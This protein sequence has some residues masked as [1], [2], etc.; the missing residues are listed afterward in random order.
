MSKKRKA[1]K[2]MMTWGLFDDE[3][4]FVAFEQNKDYLMEYK[5]YYPEAKIIRVRITPA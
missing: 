2:P 3:F 1:V 4:G 5:C